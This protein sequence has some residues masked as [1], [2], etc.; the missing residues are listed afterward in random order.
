[1]VEENRNRKISEFDKIELVDQNNLS[2]ILVPLS[3]YDDKSN[4]YINAIVN[5][6]DIIKTSYSSV[7]NTIFNDPSIFWEIFG[8]NNTILNL[9]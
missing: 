7:I 8:E 5:I 6:N 3:I 4:S 1:M 9:S 2:Y